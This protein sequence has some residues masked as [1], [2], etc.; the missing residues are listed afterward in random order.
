[1]KSNKPYSIIIIAAILFM[2][3]LQKMFVAFAFHIFYADLFK[4]MIDDNS[5]FFP[6]MPLYPLLEVISNNSLIASLIYGCFGIVQS[7]FA[8]FLY[9]GNNFA[10]VSTIF[11]LWFE[12]LAYSIIATMMIKLFSTFVFFDGDFEKYLAIVYNWVLIGIVLLQI[13]GI[14]VMNYFLT[15]NKLKEYCR[16]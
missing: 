10:R 7:F 9:R 3:G 5:T 4:I 14:V 2:I 11:L 1:M 13:L 15:R 16:R 12:Y 6:I 8:I